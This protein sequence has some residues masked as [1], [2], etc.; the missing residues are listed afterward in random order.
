MKVLISEQK[1][2]AIVRQL[3]SSLDPDK[4]VLF[5]SRARGDYRPDSDLDLLI[6]KDSPLPRHLRVRSAY[7]ALRGSGVPK[8]LLWF[9][10]A[11]IAEW[12]AVSHYISTRALREGKILYEKQH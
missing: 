8:D 11:E 3:V 7:A 10:P 9:T 2:S 12:S 6:V 5:G 1:L 4:I